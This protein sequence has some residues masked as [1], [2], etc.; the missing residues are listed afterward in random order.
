MFCDLVWSFTSDP[1]RMSLNELF[2]KI[3]YSFVLEISGPFRVVD[4]PGYTFG[5]GLSECV[6]FCEASRENLVKMSKIV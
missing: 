4:N 6:I 5:H 2:F 3:V 1:Q